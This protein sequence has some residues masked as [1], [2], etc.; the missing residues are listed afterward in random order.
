MN[1]EKS[2]QS[3]E[4]VPTAVI[5]L[6]SE[7][8]DEPIKDARLKINTTLHVLSV[9]GI[10]NFFIAMSVINV[11]KEQSHLFIKLYAAG[12]YAG[13]LFG[14]MYPL[15]AWAKRREITH[16]QVVEE[17]AQEEAINESTTAEN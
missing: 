12:S 17:S 15:S 9:L 5:E 6:P 2:S 14:I 1:P 10:V 8:I 11:D 7:A 16:P 13:Y 4:S 3:V